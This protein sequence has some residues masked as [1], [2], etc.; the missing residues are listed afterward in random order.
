MTYLLQQAQYQ[1]APTEKTTWLGLKRSIL[2]K[3]LYR[4]RSLTLKVNFL[5]WNQAL[6]PDLL[7]VGRKF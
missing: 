3:S 1:N 2:R 4:K 5:A 6:S 7:Q